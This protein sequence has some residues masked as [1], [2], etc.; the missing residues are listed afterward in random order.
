MNAYGQLRDIQSSISIGCDPRQDLRS[1]LEGLLIAAEGPPVL[2]VYSWDFPV[3]VIGCHQPLDDVDLAFCRAN[4]IPVL[5]RGSGG[6]GV[7]HHGDLGVSLALPVSHPW[8][9]GIRKLYHAFGVAMAETLQNLGFPVALLQG[10]AGG[11]DSPVCFEHHGH[12]GLY[13]EDKRVFGSAQ[14]RR[15]TAVMIHGTLLLGFD[16]DLHSS[17][18]GPGPARLRQRITS[19]GAAHRRHEIAFEIVESLSARVVDTGIEE[20]NDTWG[21]RLP[22]GLA[23]TDE[24]GAHA[25]N[26]DL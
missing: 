3:S 21:G 22:A 9:G 23:A 16:A 10:D 19:L 14:V 13:L 15:Q 24:G 5:R 8:A 12:D 11:P 1:D 20:A 18:F 4:S 6:R 7:I 2:R 26:D 25:T 17:V